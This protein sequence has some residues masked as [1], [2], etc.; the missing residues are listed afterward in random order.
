M[1]ARSPRLVVELQKLLK[2][3]FWQKTAHNPTPSTE[4]Q[5]AKEATHVESCQVFTAD[6]VESCPVTYWEKAAVAVLVIALGILAEK[7]GVSGIAY[8]AMVP[9][10]GYSKLNSSRG[11]KKL[12]SF[13]E[14]LKGIRKDSP[15]AEILPSLGEGVVITEDDKGSIP[16]GYVQILTLTKTSWLFGPEEMR[17]GL[18]ERVHLTSNPKSTIGKIAKYIGSLVTANQAAWLSIDGRAVVTMDKVAPTIEG[19]PPHQ[20]VHDG[21]VFLR[22]TDLLLLADPTYQG[23]L[24]MVGRL[25]QD[26]LLTKGLLHGVPD[27]F[28]PSGVLA[29]AS[30]QKGEIAAKDLGNQS[31]LVRPGSAKHPHFKTVLSLQ[32][33][34]MIFGEEITKP[35]FQQLIASCMDWAR[36]APDRWVASAAHA[37][38]EESVGK[39]ESSL[40]DASRN[41]ALKALFEKA[42]ISEWTT[43]VLAADKVNAINKATRKNSLTMIAEDASGSM[44]WSILLEMLPYASLND[45]WVQRGETPPTDLAEKA[46]QGRKLEAVNA[47]G[48]PILYLTPVLF[49]RWKKGNLDWWRT[50]VFRRPTGTTSGTI[51]EVRCLP[52]GLEMFPGDERAFFVPTKEVFAKVWSANEGGDLDDEFVVVRGP[53]VKF[54]VDGLAWRKQAL[55]PDEVIRTAEVNALLQKCNGLVT[56]IESLSLE[57]INSIPQAE[58]ILTGLFDLTIEQNAPAIGEKLVRRIVAIQRK[59]AP[60]EVSLGDIPDNS[61]AKILDLVLNLEENP[62]GPM[63]GLAANAQ[64]WAVGL[65]IGLVTLP[66][67][68]KGDHAGIIFAICEAMLSDVVDA[69]VKGVGFADA[70]K[71]VEQILLVQLY[72]DWALATEDADGLSMLPPLRKRAGRGMKALINAPIYLTRSHENGL[73]GEPLYLPAKDGKRILTAVTC[74]KMTN[75]LFETWVEFAEWLKHWATGE[76]AAVEKTGGAGLLALLAAV[77][78]GEDSQNGARVSVAYGYLSK[79]MDEVKNRLGVLRRMEHGYQ[80]TA[81]ERRRLQAFCQLP[82]REAFGQIEEQFGTALSSEEYD[83]L[84]VG[85]SAVA[86]RSPK[87]LNIEEDA[88]TGTFRAWGGIP[89]IAFFTDSDGVRGTWTPMAKLLNRKFV[90]EGYQ[91]VSEVFVRVGKDARSLDVDSLIGMGIGEVLSQPGLQLAFGSA[92]KANSKL[93][94]VEGQNT[95]AERLAFMLAPYQ[96]VSTTKKALWAQ[97]VETWDEEANAISVVEVTENQLAGKSSW[98][99]AE[100]LRYQEVLKGVIPGQVANVEVTEGIGLENRALVDADGNKTYIKA[101]PVMWRLI[102]E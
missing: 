94:W 25:V 48:A 102:M 39:E 35:G 21:N 86:L 53:L 1:F 64:M 60:K 95:L 32:S 26:D 77:E 2:V 73:D 91:V 22:R 89:T 6:T 12:Q 29:F 88:V 3:F 71:A 47:D 8:A 31:L 75:P 92:A 44:L 23:Y 28:I 63:V 59:A 50:V 4:A 14:W 24:A 70:W 99:I 41:D 20:A 93:V 78:A 43:S 36:T 38:D 34:L 72:T 52:I 61:K 51:C 87:P 101:A 37:L 15:L 66:E 85:I 80:R 11:S 82:T 33:L 49:K 16:E 79:A 76:A 55:W 56:K 81:L 10:A 17:D 5:M 65:A 27:H 57:E 74:K 84:L 100:L 96:S 7:L 9:F 19:E 83:R 40:L 68:L 58:E 54:A 46:T 98:E 97:K 69:S 90:T 45:L 30:E 67:N 42:G 18:V 62:F 13:N